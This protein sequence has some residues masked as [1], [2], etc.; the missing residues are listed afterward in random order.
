[1]ALSA[2][3]LLVETRIGE[4]LELLLRKL[5]GEGLSHIR[6]AYELTNRADYFLSPETVRRWC[7]DLDA[8][9]KETERAS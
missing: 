8:D 1:M 9:E 6:I 5:R 7:N 4:S 3:Y 2:A